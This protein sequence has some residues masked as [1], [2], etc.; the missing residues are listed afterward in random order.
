MRHL[1]LGAAAFAAAA[2]AIS[3]CGGSSGTG[4]GSSSPPPSSSSAM[5]SGTATATPVGFATSVKYTQIGTAKV[6]TNGGGFALYWFAPDTSTQSKCYGACA[7]YWPPLKGPVH[8]KGI[9]GSFGT[10]KRKD[11]TAQA[12]YDGRPLYTYLGDTAPGEATGNGI[13]SFG[14]I[15]HEVTIGGATPSPSQGSGGY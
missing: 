11:G 2:V 1:W 8:E 14:G 15:W 13:K 12:T 3:A 10:I 6:L 5:H 9:M 7:H 4:S